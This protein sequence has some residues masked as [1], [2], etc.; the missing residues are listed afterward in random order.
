MGRIMHGA[1]SSPESYHWV[2]RNSNQLLL[3]GNTIIHIPCVVLFL[4]KNFTHFSLPDHQL[5]QTDS[6]H[7]STQICQQSD[8]H[9]QDNPKKNVR[10]SREIPRRSLSKSSRSKSR[11]S[12]RNKSRRSRSR[13]QG[14]HG[15]SGK[16]K[17]NY[18][19]SV[20]LSPSRQTK[21][22]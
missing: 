3:R 14:K 16:K 11:E 8:Q 17:R 10:S 22:R 9:E 12:P 6:S 2:Q 4:N 7:Q 13:S 20:S 15:G 21:K 18:S 19:R 5:K 1:A